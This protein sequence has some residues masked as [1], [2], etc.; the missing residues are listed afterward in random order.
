MTPRFDIKKQVAKLGADS[1]LTSRGRIAYKLFRVRR[2]GSLGPLFINQRQRIP[3]RTRLAAEA[4]PTKGYAFR[5]GW[6][7]CSH[8]V[9]PHLSKTGRRWYKVRI[10]NFIAHHRPEAQGGLWFIAQEMTVLCPTA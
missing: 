5:P 9:A 2:D 10:D 4:H 8:P 6:H 3:L 1:L 7:V